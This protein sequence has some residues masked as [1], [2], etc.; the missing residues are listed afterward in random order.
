MSSQFVFYMPFLVIF[1]YHVMLPVSCMFLCLAAYKFV[2]IHVNYQHADKRMLLCVLCLNPISIF[3]LKM[4][5]R[6]S[7]LCGYIGHGMLE[8]NAFNQEEKQ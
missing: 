5:Q 2:F 8:M 6:N 1:Y 4:D 7:C 3:N